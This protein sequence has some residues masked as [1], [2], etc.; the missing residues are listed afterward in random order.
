MVNTQGMISR[1]AGANA[2]GFQVCQH[3]EH[4]VLCMNISRIPDLV[5]DPKIT[6]EKD[7]ANELIAEQG[8]WTLL[9]IKSRDPFAVAVL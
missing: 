4:L 8:R 6:S 2:L 5:S 9:K 3:A 1:R 7:Y